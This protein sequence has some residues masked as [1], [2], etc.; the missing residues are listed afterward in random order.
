MA[1]ARK[2]VAALHAANAGDIP[3]VVG[4]TIPHRDIDVLTESGVAAVLP[5]STPLDDGSP[6][7]GRWQKA[8]APRRWCRPAVGGWSAASQR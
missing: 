1:L 4:N 3:V 7:C 6:R 8:A 2:V 5:M